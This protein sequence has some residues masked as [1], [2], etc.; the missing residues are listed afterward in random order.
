MLNMKMHEKMNV[1]ITHEHMLISEISF[2]YGYIR[3]IF[4]TFKLLNIP[5]KLK[6]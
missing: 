4:I 5:G 6:L 1:F 3:L 2:E